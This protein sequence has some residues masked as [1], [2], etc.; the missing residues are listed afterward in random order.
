MGN[1]NV[2][3]SEEIANGKEMVVF[4]RDS[5]TIYDTKAGTET[6]CLRIVYADMKIK[7]L[8]DWRNSLIF[9]VDQPGLEPGTS[10][11]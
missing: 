7:E 2:D 11:L 9:S 5:V 4:H 3:K 6:V 8:R 1:S 10:R